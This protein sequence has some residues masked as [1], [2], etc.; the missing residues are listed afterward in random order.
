MSVDVVIAWSAQIK[1]FGIGSHNERN[2][3]THIHTRMMFHNFH[4]ILIKSIYP[5]VKSTYP[6][7]ML[8]LRNF[9][10]FQT[11]KD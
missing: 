7:K 2:I 11:C 5:L 6:Y 8:N 9:L 4:V 1:Q 10:L 3:Y